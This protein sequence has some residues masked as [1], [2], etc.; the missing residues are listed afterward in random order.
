[1]KI[2][3]IY[4]LSVP[5]VL[6]VIITF[7]ILRRSTDRTEDH[8]K[9]STAL[10]AM[11][12]SAERVEPDAR[13]RERMRR[14]S[15][16]LAAQQW[17]ERLLEKHPDLRPAFR[18]VPDGENGYLQFVRFAESLGTR[19]LLPEDIGE[20]FNGQASW[21][22]ARARAWLAEH[23]QHLGRLLEIA[24][25]PDRSCKGIPFDKLH[26]L[27]SLCSDFN[28]MLRASARLELEDGD[29]EAALRYMRASTCLAGHFT[30]I[31]APTMMGEVIATSA[32]IRAQESFR[33]NFLPVI[34]PTALASWN[35]ALFRKEKPASEYSRVI[36][37]EWSFLIRNIL[38]PQLLSG[39]SVDGLRVPD[40]DGFSEAYANAI[41]K[42]A[43]GISTLG[44]DRFD[45]NSARFGKAPEAGLD[46]ETASAVR[47]ALFGFDGI[48][49]SLGHSLTRTTMD[50]A[51][52]A[53][54][55]GNEMP[56]DP[57]SGKPF[58]WDP[59]TRTL[60]PPEERDNVDPIKVP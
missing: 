10:S 5:P 45:V 52:I 55:T 31:E 1:M 51:S 17:Y 60:S 11:T 49:E 43:E 20:M 56:S 38:L 39:Q 58:R 8:E 29:P 42:S 21:D 16:E 22:S 23:Q 30:D 53:L 50:A 28:G 12:R 2:N 24:E 3:R 36:K 33:E 54:L 44:A 15:I 59:D 47:Q 34:D 41:R 26:Q 14:E 32:R 25:L 27:A 35:D 13:T 4:L 48:V 7:M 57:V 19:R 9:E 40:V 37:G 46:P 18:D 6:A